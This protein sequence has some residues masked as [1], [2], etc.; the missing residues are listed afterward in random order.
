LPICLEPEIGSTSEALWLLPVPEAVSFYSPHSHLRRLVS[1]GSRN[2][3]MI[4]FKEG[5][6]NKKR[7]E[8]VCR[9]LNRLDQKRKFPKI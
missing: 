2:P 9:I 1:V 4:F 7:R 6:A 5:Y 3:N 8:K